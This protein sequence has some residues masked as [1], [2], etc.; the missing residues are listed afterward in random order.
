MGFLIAGISFVIGV[1]YAIMKILGT[2]FPLGNPTIVILI[3]FMG[4]VQLISVGVLGEYIARIYDEVKQRPKFIVED[5]HGL[6]RV[7]TEARRRRHIDSIP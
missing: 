1:V 7:T 6:D 3:L 5:V 4:G 2:P